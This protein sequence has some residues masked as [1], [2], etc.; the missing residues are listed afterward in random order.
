MKATLAPPPHPALQRTRP[1]NASDGENAPARP[2]LGLAAVA[3]SWRV[4]TQ[5]ACFSSAQTLAIQLSTSLTPPRG[6]VERDAKKADELAASN[7]GGHPLSG[8]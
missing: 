1:V 3:S 8:H 2:W 4:P 5:R 6:A 7:V